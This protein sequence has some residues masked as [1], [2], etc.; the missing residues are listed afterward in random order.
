MRA[1]LKELLDTIPGFDPDAILGSTAK[2]LV[3]LL[4]HGESQ[5][6]ETW[7]L[8]HLLELLRREITTR[9]PH[10]LSDVRRP[11]SFWAPKEGPDNESG[12][13]EEHQEW[14]IEDLDRYA[15][16]LAEPVREALNALRTFSPR[17]DLH[18]LWS[19]QVEVTKGYR[20]CL[21]RRD[22]VGGSPGMP[23]G[24]LVTR[25]H[26]AAVALHQGARHT[27]R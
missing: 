20:D 22:A 6:P 12:Q 18:Q 24:D 23:A 1:D 8:G 11:R 19:G 16:R 5:S 27:N 15:D 7:L 26:A 25:I 4:A 2:A 14:T 9:F 21:N 3:A 13:E 17:A 10:A